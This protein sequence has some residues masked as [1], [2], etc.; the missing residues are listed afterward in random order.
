MS[1]AASA[2]GAA[3]TLDAFHRG[4]FWLVQPERSGHRA[5]LDAML[6]A[7]AVPDTFDGHAADLGAG[8]GAAGLAVISRCPKA[9]VTLVERAPEMAQ[10]ARE[11]LRLEQN[12][13]LRDR[14]DVIEADVTTSAQNRAQ[15]GLQD[16]QFDFIV[17]NPPFNSGSDRATPN[18]LKRDAHVMDA[19]MWEKWL[20]TAAAT[21][22]PGAG[23][24]LIA[25][26]ESLADI[27]A[28]ISGR[29][30]AAE[31]MTIHPREAGP[32][33]RIVLRARFGSRKRLSIVPPLVVHEPDGNRFTQRTDDICNGL[34]SLFGD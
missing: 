11:T 5:G 7:A 20:R 28:A 6:L 27:L 16:N 23:L 25:R 9:S 21:A 31:L 24:A 30:G 26:P 19:E 4:R 18:E 17:M 29:S 2:S 8:P 34:Q 15:A 3:T 12:R 32:A 13:H 1:E 14:A 33:I 22:R 10:M